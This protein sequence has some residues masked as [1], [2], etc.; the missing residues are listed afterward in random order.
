MDAKLNIDADGAF[1]ESDMDHE[2][3]GTVTDA[4]A[5][6]RMP[7]ILDIEDEELRAETTRAV[8]LLPDFFWTA[9]AAKRHHPPEHRSRHGLWL[10]TKRVVTAF[11]R[12]A[13]SMVKQGHLS[14]YEID[15]GRSACILHDGFKYGTEPTPVQSTSGSHDVIAA[16]WLLSNTDLPSGVTK[17][18]EH[19]NGA[20][21]AGDAPDS[22][23]SQMVHVAD[24][25]ASD[26]NARIAVKE[27]HTVLREHFPRVQER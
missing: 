17:A 6:E 19:H 8:A 14:W 15:M 20:W 3:H 1:E 26:E 18:V 25:F 10:H 24:L 5:Q 2:L 21:Y 22:H 12:V 27:P 11:E 16:S 7:E 4:E 13:E 9:P 23:L